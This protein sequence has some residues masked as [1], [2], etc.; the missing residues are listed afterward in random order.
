[1][2]SP[3][4]GLKWITM[5]SDNQGGRRLDKRPPGLREPRVNVLGHHWS[6]WDSSLFRAAVSEWAARHRT[7]LWFHHDPQ[8][9]RLRPLAGDAALDRCSR[10]GFSSGS[11]SAPN[12]DLIRGTPTS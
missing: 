8:S 9:D 2:S 11:T 4:D 12:T 7:R 5:Q 10:A 6:V 1:M 3:W